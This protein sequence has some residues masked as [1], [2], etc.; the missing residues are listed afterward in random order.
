MVLSPRHCPAPLV[1][2]ILIILLGVVLLLNQLGLLPHGMAVQFWPAALIVVGL[3]KLIAG[4]DRR[5]RVV[6]GALMCAGVLLQT[7]AMGYTHLTWNEVWPMLIIFAGVL[8]LVRALVPKSQQ[9]PSWTS[10][11]DLSSSFFV[12]GGGERK[13]NTKEFRGARLFSIFGGYQVDLTR[14]DMA[15]DEAFIE[16]NAVFGGGEIRVPT[17]WRVVVQGTGIFGGYSDET[18]H[19]QPDGNAPAKTLYVRGFTVFGGIEVRN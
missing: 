5:D 17:A 15:S 3:I 4:N 11:E 13:L 10:P 8:V 12:F 18:Q 19:F 6:G 9:P 14:A 2:G 7:N 1:A 16:A